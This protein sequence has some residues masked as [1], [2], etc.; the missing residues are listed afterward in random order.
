MVVTA[1]G[2]TPGIGKTALA[3]H[4]AHQLLP[5]FPDGNLYADLRGYTRDQIP[6]EPSEILEVFLRRLG[7]SAGEMPTT[8]EE[9]SGLL[10][11]MLASRRLLIILD[12][13]V[14]EGQI[15]PL[16]PGAGGS[17]VLITS[18]SALPGLEVDERIGLDVLPE[19]AAD[20]LLARLIGLDRAEAESEALRHV[21]NWCGRL[22]LA[23]RIAGQLL[24]AHPA[25]PVARL[26]RMLA[27]EA[28]RLRHL[29]AGDLQVRTAFA[30]SYRYLADPDAHMFRLL[31]L[32]PGPDLDT[33]AAASLGGISLEATGGILDRL[34]EAHLVTEDDSERFRMHDLLRLFARDICHKA[35]EQA[36]R[37][38]AEGRLVRHYTKVAEHLDYSIFPHT[39]AA[40]ALERPGESLPTPRQALVRFEAE[41]LSLLAA[42]SLA[43]QRGWHE[44]VWQLSK[45]MANVLTLLHYF[46]D[47]LTIQ[48]AALAAAR[49][50]GNAAAEGQALNDLGV[51]YDELRRFD[52]ANTC[53]QESIAIRREIG[54]WRGEGQ[55]LNNL[56]LNYLTLRRFDEAINSFQNALARFREIGHKD[57]VVMA[58]DNLGQ[59]YIDLRQ[60][61]KAITF[62]QESLTVSQEIGDRHSEGHVLNN[63]GITYR[64]L[65][66]FADAIACHRRSL[67]ICREIGDRHGEGEALHNLGCAHLD[68]RQPARAAAYW[69]DAA[70][71][72]RNAGDHELA[73]RL[74]SWAAELQP[75]R[76]LSRRRQGPSIQSS[77]D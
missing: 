73:A 49:S 65:Q 56:G 55:A 58:L 8:L 2:G 52:E 66:Q 62:L 54:D 38:A 39:P 31:G 47:M 29:S 50:A 13:A 19:K 53:Y 15:R 43:K 33:A 11:Q 40:Q 16:L 14:T 42:L 1:I 51:V 18:R 26:A 64:E 72:M 45:N 35:D 24:V 74:E 12:N 22:P 28:D 76:R 21:R 67:V 60:F 32:H 63:L 3:V 69:R 41:R 77:N 44:Q 59:A 5:Q 9:Q 70:A 30:V 23:L 75:R 48:Q 37:D 17:L 34:V 20:A 68:L 57:G 27:D 36:S 6:A 10:R 71:V 4:V 25:W 61:N 46:D 7:V